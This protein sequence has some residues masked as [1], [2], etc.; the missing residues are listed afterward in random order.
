MAPLPRGVLDERAIGRKMSSE[1]EH[2]HFLDAVRLPGSSVA[3]VFTA[4]LLAAATTD[5]SSSGVYEHHIF[6]TMRA[7]STRALEIHS[8]HF[9]AMPSSVDSGDYT[10][11]EGQAYILIAMHTSLPCWKDKCA[12]SDGHLEYAQCRARELKMC[13][14]DRFRM[15]RIIISA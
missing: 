2:R 6:S 15:Y 10:I 3:L 9:R 8:R 5:Q 11:R 13:E 4:G 14:A 1:V 7:A 12:I